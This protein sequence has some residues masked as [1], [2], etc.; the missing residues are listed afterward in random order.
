[1]CSPLL[2]GRAVTDTPDM[3]DVQAALQLTVVA[4]AQTADSRRHQVF[5]AAHRHRIAVCIRAAQISVMEN[6]SN[7]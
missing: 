4:L 1:M 7:A 6:W 5:K 3:I 2:K